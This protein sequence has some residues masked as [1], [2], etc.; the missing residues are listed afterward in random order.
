MLALRSP[1]SEP[2]EVRLVVGNPPNKPLSTDLLSPQR[3]HRFLCSFQKR[4]PFYYTLRIW[5]DY[6]FRQHCGHYTR[7]ELFTKE[8]ILMTLA[9]EMEQ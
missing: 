1:S 8:F 9:F 7:L 3:I 6:T 2:T 4:F 5:L